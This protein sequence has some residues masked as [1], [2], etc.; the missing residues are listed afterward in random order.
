MVGNPSLA[1]LRQ[2][3]P[4]SGTSGR[5]IAGER[6]GNSFHKPIGEVRHHLSSIGHIQWSFFF[7]LQ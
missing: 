4:N 7:A 1:G 5:L 2:D 3:C 6:S